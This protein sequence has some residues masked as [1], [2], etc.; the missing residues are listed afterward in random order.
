[1]EAIRKNH[2]EDLESDLDAQGSSHAHTEA[3]DHLDHSQQ[4]AERTLKNTSQ[5][6]VAVKCESC[7]GSGKFISWSGRVVGPCFKCEGKGEILRAPGYA[8]AKAKREER[9]VAQKVEDNAL[10]LSGQKLLQEKFPE[11]IA[12]LIAY[13][14]RGIH[15]DFM[16]SLLVRF[17]KYGEL[18]EGQIGALTRGIEKRKARQAEREAAV[19]AAGP[20][21]GL[22]ISSI[23]NGR[24]AV[25]EGETRLKIMIKRPGPDSRWHGHIFV[26][27][28]A[29]YGQRQSYGSQAPGKAYRGKLIEQLKVIMADPHAASIAYGKLVGACGVCGRVL[30]DA[31]SIAAGIGPICAGKFE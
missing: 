30:E 21:E 24:Y 25:P 9:K 10:R 23:P 14:N 12:D 15:N 31:E 13:A 18:S 28:A 20:I 26:S 5:Q 6:R 4:F 16:E 19:A 29:A 3:C 17:N 1:M 11:E 27:D 2:F 8:V 22:D 7:R